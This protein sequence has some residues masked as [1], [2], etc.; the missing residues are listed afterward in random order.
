MA[1]EA[2]NAPGFLGQVHQLILTALGALQ[3]RSELLAVEWQ[4]ERARRVESVITAMVFVFLGCM[5]AAL[6]TGIVIF[7]CPEEMRLYAAG[8]FMLLY[9]AGAIWSGLGLRALLNRAPFAE[10]LRQLEKDRAWLK[11]L[12]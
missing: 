1:G 12:K 8:V 7:L 4:Q 3:N 11:S 2:P 10:T 6:L 9:L 5:A